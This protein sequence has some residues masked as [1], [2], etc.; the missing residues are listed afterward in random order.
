MIKDGRFEILRLF[1]KENLVYQKVEDQSVTEK[2][3]RPSDVLELAI[4]EENEQKENTVF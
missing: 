1:V 2:Y 4:Q 3:F